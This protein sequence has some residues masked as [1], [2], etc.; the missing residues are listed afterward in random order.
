MSLNK[1]YLINILKFEAVGKKEVMPPHIIACATMWHE[2]RT[3]MLEMLKSLLRMD[4]DQCLKMSAKNTI[5]DDPE[6][7]ANF[8]TYEGKRFEKF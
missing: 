8:Y 4:N 2:T 3:E 1:I 7:E 6:A 5:I